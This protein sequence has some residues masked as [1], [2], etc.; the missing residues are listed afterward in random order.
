MLGLHGFRGFFQAGDNLCWAAIV[1]SLDRYR[2]N[3]AGQPAA[4]RFARQ[5]DVAERRGATRPACHDSD[6][7]ERRPNC[8]CLK[9][10]A[11]REDR[12]DLALSDMDLLEGWVELGGTAGLNV[13]GMVTRRWDLEDLRRVLGDNRVV[14]VRVDR[15]RDKDRTPEHFVVV[16]MCGTNDDIVWAYDPADENRTGEPETFGSLCERL[17]ITHK[18]VTKRLR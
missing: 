4:Q 18:Y 11:D 16:V 5:C 2:A 14:V 10:D 1:A 13:G 12:V 9:R 15:N 6:L 8:A 7:S 3:S 17:T